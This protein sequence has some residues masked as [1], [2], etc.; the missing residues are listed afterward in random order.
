MLSHLSVGAFEV[1]PPAV[2]VGFDEFCVD[3]PSAIR[4][5]ANDSWQFRAGYTGDFILSQSFPA[6]SWSTSSSDPRSPR[7]AVSGQF[8]AGNGS[9]R[10]KCLNSANE[11]ADWRGRSLSPGHRDEKPCLSSA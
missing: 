6:Q 5:A 10:T 9:V 1:C 11:C 2:K 7:P 3:E 4:H 8:A